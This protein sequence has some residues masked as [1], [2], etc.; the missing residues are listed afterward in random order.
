M[1]MLPLFT[2]APGATDH[3]RTIADVIGVVDNPTFSG[4][5]NY[6]IIITDGVGIHDTPTQ[7]LVLFLPRP[8]I[9]VSQA[10]LVR[11]HYW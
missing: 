8:G 1:P 2:D 10:A 4:P 6:S 3:S 5:V 9:Q 11:S 7:D